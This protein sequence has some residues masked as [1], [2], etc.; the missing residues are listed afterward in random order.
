MRTPRKKNQRDLNLPLA[1]NDSYSERLLEKGEN[2]E[3]SHRLAKTT[4]DD[5]QVIYLPPQAK[6][7]IAASQGM[8]WP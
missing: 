2:D 7:P 3:R 8:T 5:A 4:N 1:R 6:L